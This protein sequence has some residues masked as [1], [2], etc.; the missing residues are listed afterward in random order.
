MP[1]PNDPDK[2]PGPLQQAGFS[3]VGR[4]LLIHCG[5]MAAFLW[6]WENLRQRFAPY[7][8]D[9]PLPTRTIFL[10]AEHAW[11]VL[12]VFAV[13][14]YMLLRRLE[15]IGPH[16]LDIAEMREVLMIILGAFLL[17]TG[18]AIYIP[19]SSISAGPN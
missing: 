1:F 10:M 7:M 13:L 17:G 6:S 15:K 4:I 5:A 3:R 2:R 16:A 11:I 8:Q 18:F 14:D 12:S 9:V 19:L